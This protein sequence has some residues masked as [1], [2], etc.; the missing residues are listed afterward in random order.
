MSTSTSIH[1]NELLCY[2]VHKYG[3]IPS[4][5]LKMIVNNVYSL[6]AISSAKNALVGLVDAME[7]GRH[8]ANSTGGGNEG[9]Y[10]SDVEDIFNVLVYLDEKQLSKRLPCFVAANP[11]MLPSHNLLEG[12]LVGIMSQFTNIDNKLSESTKYSHEPPRLNMR[13]FSVFVKQL[14]R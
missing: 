7:I 3:K 1:V 9:K 8:R 4:K 11:D 6:E 12:D 13:C 14:R 10:K 2:S 5:Q